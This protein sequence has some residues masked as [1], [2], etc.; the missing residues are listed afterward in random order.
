M[1]TAFNLMFLLSL[2]QV[3]HVFGLIYYCYMEVCYL[4]TS[5]V[6]VLFLFENLLISDFVVDQ[7]SDNLAI[8][9][10]VFSCHNELM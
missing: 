5:G 6:Y 3:L 8:R 7:Y 2:L 4:H 10:R 9:R 1:I